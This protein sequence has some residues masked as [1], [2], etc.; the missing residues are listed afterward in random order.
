M[1]DVIFMIRRAL[2]GYIQTPSDKNYTDVIQALD[3][4]LKS[5]INLWVP[6]SV[7]VSP[8][9]EEM[10]SPGMIAGDDDLYYYIVCLEEYD[11]GERSEGVQRIQVNFNALMETVGA[12][13]KLG[14]ICLN[15]WDGGCFITREHINGLLDAQAFALMD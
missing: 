15:P 9:G 1:D 6:G 13:T 3:I 8:D 7:K 5:K 2:S 14:G 10:L 11:I 12:N 4:G